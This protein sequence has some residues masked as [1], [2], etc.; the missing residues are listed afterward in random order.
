MS[1][2]TDVIE[3]VKAWRAATSAWPGLRL[4]KDEAARR[5]A[6][7]AL[8]LARCGSSMNSINVAICEGY[9]PPGQLSRLVEATQGTSHPIVPG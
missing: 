4:D 3:K 5:R 2:M 6:E 9:M 7:R 8:V 1:N